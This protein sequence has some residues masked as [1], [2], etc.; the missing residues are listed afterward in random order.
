LFIFKREAFTIKD[1]KM[2]FDQ[3]TRTRPDG[4]SEVHSYKKN[5]RRRLKYNPS[6]VVDYY[7][8]AL[9][10]GDRASVSI[11]KTCLKFGICQSTVYRYLLL[12]KEPEE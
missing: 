12:R 4:S 8:E 2:N 9:S 6:D 11:Q 3:R 5:G 7:N 1:E 10:D